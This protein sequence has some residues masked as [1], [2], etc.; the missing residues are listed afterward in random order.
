MFKLVY[1]LSLIIKYYNIDKYFYFKDGECPLFF[2][3]KIN[4][5]KWFNI[6]EFDKNHESDFNFFPKVPR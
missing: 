3:S 5:N 6:S 2:W 1:Q 4:I